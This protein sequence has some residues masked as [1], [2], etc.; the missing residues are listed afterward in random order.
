MPSTPMHGSMQCTPNQ[1]GVLLVSQWQAMAEVWRLCA[2][3]TV[4]SMDNAGIDVMVYPTW[5]NPA[6]LVGN[7]GSPDGVPTPCPLH[8]WPAHAWAGSD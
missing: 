5:S 2:Q 8:V 7:Y 4:Q 1:L 6:L 3:A